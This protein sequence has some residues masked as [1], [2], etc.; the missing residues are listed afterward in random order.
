MGGYYEKLMMYIAC[1]RDYLAERRGGEIV[2]QPEA[3]EYLW[4]KK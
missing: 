4:P 2:Y 3:Q 1:L